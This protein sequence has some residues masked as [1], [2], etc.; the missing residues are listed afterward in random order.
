MEN[1]SPRVIPGG[2]P[3]LVISEVNVQQVG[4]GSGQKKNIE[5]FWTSQACG[6]PVS[7]VKQPDKKW[8]LSQF[9]SILSGLFWFHEHCKRIWTM[10]FR[11]PVR[12]FRCMYVR[13]CIKIG[14]QFYN[15]WWIQTTVTSHINARHCHISNVS[16][17]PYPMLVRQ[18]INWFTSHFE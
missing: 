1:F 17:E 10:V 12:F 15:G 18:V 5:Y 14:D 11:S 13:V 7:W 6:L 4:P 8:L 2:Q 3:T 9:R 16:D